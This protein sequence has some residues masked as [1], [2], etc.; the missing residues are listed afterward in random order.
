MDYFDP[1]ETYLFIDELSRSTE[2]GRADR[3]L[4]GE[5]EAATRERLYFART[6]EKNCL[7]TVKKSWDGWSIFPVLRWRHWIP[8]SCGLKLNGLMAF[9]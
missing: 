2:R 1:K 5:H 7:G 8:K 6:D 4:K 9:M 3:T